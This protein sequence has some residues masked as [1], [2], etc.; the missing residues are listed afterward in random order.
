MSIARLTLVLLMAML[1]TS[2]QAET[3]NCTPITALPATITAQGIYCLT[4]KLGTSQTSGAAITIT[5]NNVTLDLNGWK[6]DGGSAGAGTGATGIYSSAANVTVKNGI[7][8]GF[9]FGIELDGSG[10]VV[11]D[12]QANQNTRLGIYVTGL[13][14]LVE[15]NQVV[16]TGGTTSAANVDARGIEADGSDSTVSNNMVSGL[17]ATGTASEYGVVTLGANGTIRNNVVS[18]TALPTGGGTSDGIYNL[19][20]IALNNT[21]SNFVTGIFNSGG[22]YAYNTANNCTTSYSGGT[23]GAGNSP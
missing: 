20:S 16:N 11:Q 8:R 23:A 10:A 2:I 17:T 15:H 18:N 19:G 5:A 22:I 14:A 13:G 3:I 4:H 6:V 1:A 21:V 7:V 12:M 9:Y